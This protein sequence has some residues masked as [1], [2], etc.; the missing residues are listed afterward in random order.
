MAN[1]LGGM[2][3][4]NDGGIKR[5]D[6][7]GLVSPTSEG[8]LARAAQCIAG[9]RTIPKQ[10]LV[11]K[12][13]AYYYARQRRRPE[14]LVLPV[15]RVI[16]KDGEQTPLLSRPQ[17]RSARATRRLHRP[18]AAMAVQRTASA[19]L[20]RVDAGPTVPRRTDVADVAG[21]SRSGRDG[22]LSR[23]PS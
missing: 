5:L 3:T 23:R 20:I 6:S 1:P 19:R 8:E 15:Y 2:A 9:D 4:M 17:H 16:L 11:N 22:C 13:D 10:S 14:Q 21:R 12:E 18:W 7:S